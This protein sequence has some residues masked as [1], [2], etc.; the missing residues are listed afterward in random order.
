MMSA[1]AMCGVARERDDEINKYIKLL[2]LHRNA[3]G[4]KIHKYFFL[5]FTPPCDAIEVVNE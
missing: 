5:G 4:R 2:V 1:S 3:H